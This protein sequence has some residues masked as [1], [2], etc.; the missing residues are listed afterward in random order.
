MRHRI[1][2]CDP[3]HWIPSPRTFQAGIYGANLSRCEREVRVVWSSIP[4]KRFL[5]TQVWMSVLFYHLRDVVI[6][7]LL[8]DLYLIIT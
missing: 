5:N 7:L 4:S 3:N 2:I 6:L 8:I 1:K